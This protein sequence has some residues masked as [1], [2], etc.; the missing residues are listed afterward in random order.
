MPLRILLVEDEVD[1]RDSMRDILN[2]E[3]FSAD[4]VGSIASYKAWRQTHS[5][6]ILIIDRQL[7]DG[8]G[9]EVLRLH[10][11][12][13]DAPVIV[14]TAKGQIEDRIEGINADADYYL[15]KPVVMNEL[16]A[17]LHRLARKLDA[18][19][20]TPW[21]LDTV[22]WQLRT[23]EGDDVQLTR[24]ELVFLSAFLEKPGLTV[25][26]QEVIRA[27][28]EQPEH[29]DVRRLEVMVRRLRNKVLDETGSSLPLSTVYGVGYVFNSPLSQ[30]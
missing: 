29:Y 27:L 23:P 3:G 1:F 28:G 6:D 24:R 21:M 19:G 2:L 22:S 14:L 9:L 25:H 16:L 17:I 15:V 20:A 13:E 11:Q 26:R 5:C 12:A 8:D 18:T 10:R 4:G 7:P 30:Q